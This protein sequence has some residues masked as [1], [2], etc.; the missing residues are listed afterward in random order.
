MVAVRRYLLNILVAL[1]QLLSAL[2]GGDPDETISSRLGKAA[3][4]DYG[5]LQVVLWTPVTGL[6]DLVFLA[7]DGPGH[8][9]RSI[10]EEEGVNAM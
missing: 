7:F 8:C 3:R 10:E 6:V 9:R 4:G 1:D 2:I 5:R